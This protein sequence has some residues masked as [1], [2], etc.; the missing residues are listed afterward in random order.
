MKKPDP[1]Q[2]MIIV[3]KVCR[4]ELLID[5]TKSTDKEQWYQD[6]CPCGGKGELKF[7]G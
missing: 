1:K 7:S 3:C 4:K 2:G 5:K 6:R